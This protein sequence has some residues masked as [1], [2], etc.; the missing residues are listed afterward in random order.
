MLQSA[1]LFLMILFSQ[2]DE[3]G[4]PSASV[5]SRHAAT[6]KVR[7]VTLIYRVGW[8]TVPWPCCTRLHGEPRTVALFHR[9]C[10]AV[11][12]REDGARPGA[13]WVPHVPPLCLSLR[14]THNRHLSIC[15]SFASLFIQTHFYSLSSSNPRSISS[16]M[17]KH[18]HTHLHVTKHSNNSPL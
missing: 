15:I 4:G 18:T 7:V 11:L 14:N 9:A 12:H 2:G 5:S 1:L 17:H 8:S 3:D 10:A 13:V 6:L 16:I